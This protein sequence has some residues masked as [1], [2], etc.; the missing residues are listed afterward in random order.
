MLKPSSYVHG[1][2]IAIDRAYIDY[3][4]FEELT[5]RGVMYPA[6]FM[7][8]TYHFLCPSFPLWD[9]WFYYFLIR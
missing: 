6:L 9:E 1:D 3:A 5:R 7:K 4:K 2:I 8:K